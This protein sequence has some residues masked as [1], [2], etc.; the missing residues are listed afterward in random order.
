MKH[1]G[2]AHSKFS[3]SGA[4][5]WFNCPGSVA[6]SEGQP[7]KES[8]YA[9]EG[10]KAH[11][12]LETIMRVMIETGATKVFYPQMSRDVPKEM[13]VYGTNAAN[14]IMGLH[15]KTPGSEVMVETRIYLDFIHK[16]MFGT[17]DGAVIDH[18]GTLHIFDYKYGAGHFVSP[19]KN[20]QMIFYAIGLAHKYGWNFK[21]VR[22]WIY[23][24]RVKGFDGP[25]YWEITT[26]EL[27][28][29]IPLF[30]EAVARV[31]NEPDH[32]VE[33]S[34]KGNWCHWCKAKSVCPLKRSKKLEQAK[35][36]FGSNDGKKENKKE[37]LRIFKSEADWKKEAKLKKEKGRKK[38][39]DNFY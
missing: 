19:I 29:Y 20:L 12:V 16:E 22:M 14:F 37:D 30:E 32:Y 10:T 33:D 15:A 5:R 21:R 18:F 1:E 8:K 35:Q 31:E 34:G 6:L 25:L 3:A 11:E 28:D 36:I 17:F 24:P 9:I 39:D 4:E 13:I 2:R 27:R 7:D 23:Q 38:E 26:Q